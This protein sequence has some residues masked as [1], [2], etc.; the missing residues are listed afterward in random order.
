[1]NLGSI[2]LEV[3]VNDIYHISKIIRH[4]VSN[5]KNPSYFP[6]YWLFNR[7]PYNGLL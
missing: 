3:K 4:D 5:E 1:M 6:L 7:D 2:Y